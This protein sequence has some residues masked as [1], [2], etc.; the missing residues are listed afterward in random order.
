[1]KRK[2]K[3]HRYKYSFSVTSK[4]LF[5]PLKVDIVRD[6][7]PYCIFYEGAFLDTAGNKFDKMPIDEKF[8]LWKHINYYGISVA[9]NDLELSF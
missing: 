1:M 8:K 2:N 3:I 5:L 4:D 9:D 7:T 6:N